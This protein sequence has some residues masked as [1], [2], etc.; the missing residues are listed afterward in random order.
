L[1]GSNP[2]S[3]PSATTASKPMNAFDEQLL[4]EEVKQMAERICWQIIPDITEKIVREEI[5]KLLQGVEKNI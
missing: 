1:S 3:T 4:K 5:Q 2:A